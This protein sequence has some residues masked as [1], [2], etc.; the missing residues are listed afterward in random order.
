MAGVIFAGL[1]WVVSSLVERRDSG[2]VER[3]S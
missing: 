2:T 1:I 3:E